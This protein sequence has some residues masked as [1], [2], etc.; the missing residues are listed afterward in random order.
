MR[1]SDINVKITGDG[2]Q[3]LGKLFCKLS[4]GLTLGKNALAKRSAISLNKALDDRGL[5][6]LSMT[7]PIRIQQQ[8][9][10]TVA[11]TSGGKKQAEGDGSN[12]PPIPP[13]SCEVLDLFL[14]PLHLDLLGLVVDLYGATPNDAVRVHITAD[15]NGGV[16]G[17]TFCELANGSQA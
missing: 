3:T 2:K 17:S 6:L 5:R 13:G 16:L 4:K 1:T 11:R 12:I 8:S 7:A 14:G 9:G 15:P 10:R